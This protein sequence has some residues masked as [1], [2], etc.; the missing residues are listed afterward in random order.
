MESITETE[1]ELEH[2]GWISNLREYL[3]IPGW[4]DSAT[5]LIHSPHQHIY[6]R[7][8]SFL[9]ILFNSDEKSIDER[10]YFFS[11]QPLERISVRNNWLSTTISSSLLVKRCF[12]KISNNSCGTCV[13]NLS[14]PPFHSNLMTKSGLEVLGAIKPLNFKFTEQHGCWNETFQYSY[15]GN[16]LGSICFVFR[17]SIQKR[18][19]KYPSALMKI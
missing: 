19:L 14:L 12:I 1:S 8:W 11:A 16:S 3:G 15:Q 10:Q 17:V 5:F 4:Q 18:A 9:G 7:T 6:Q 2:T 13:L